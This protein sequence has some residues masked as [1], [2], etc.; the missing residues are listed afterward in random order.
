MDQLLVQLTG[1]LA[2]SEV[3]KREEGSSWTTGLLIGL[4]SLIILSILAVKSWFDGRE[5]A[6]LLHE[7]AVLEE[8]KRQQVV[9][10]MFSRYQ[11]IKD[12]AVKTIDKLTDDISAIDKRVEDIKRQRELRTVRF[13][14]IQS[15]DDVDENLDH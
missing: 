15:W 4:L 6:K 5:R 11:V 7:K 1:L 13:L 3:K 2:K 10:A 8:E 14:S 12:N 9:D